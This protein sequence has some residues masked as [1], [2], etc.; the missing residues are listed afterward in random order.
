MHLLADM[1]GPQTDL[2][3]LET[4]PDYLAW[5]VEVPRDRRSAQRTS[6]PR[7]ASH[8]LS[9]LSLALMLRPLIHF[10]HFG[11]NEIVSAEMCHNWQQIKLWCQKAQRNTTRDQ[12]LDL[13]QLLYNAAPVSTF[14]KAAIHAFH[15]ICMII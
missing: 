8:K 9:S 11:G 3:S 14:A 6:S 7:P 10:P 13:K 12:L 1:F 4:W 5:K 15:I 2:S